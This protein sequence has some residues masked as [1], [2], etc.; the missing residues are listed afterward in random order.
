MQ[1]KSS[2]GQSAY[3][4]WLAYVMNE[5]RADPT[6]L[7][8]ASGVPVDKIESFLAGREDP[9]DGDESVYR[10]AEVLLKNTPRKQMELVLQA[11]RTHVDL[12]NWAS[13]CDGGCCK[14]NTAI[15]IVVDNPVP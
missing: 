10:I 15:E 4:A 11:L 12:R 3:G 6:K 14:W 13:S 9:S 2:A 8:K 7:A 1:S 5:R